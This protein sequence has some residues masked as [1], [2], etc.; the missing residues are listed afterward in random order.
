MRNKN[1]R[2]LAAALLAGLSSTAFA[3]SSLLAEYDNKG[4]VTFEFVADGASVAAMGIELPLGEAAKGVKVS[5][6]CLATPRGFASLC[7]VDGLTFKAVVYSTNPDA[8][9]PSGSL[10]R[11]QFPNGAISLAKSGEIQG[12]TLKTYDGMA[13][14]VPSEVLSAP[15]GAD[16]QRRSQQER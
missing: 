8:A 14:A 15:K 13:K 7:N 4:G 3:Q 2:F 16:S 6:N 10:G 1:L 9:L 12:L 11:V 5:E